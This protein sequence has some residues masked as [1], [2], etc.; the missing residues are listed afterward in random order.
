MYFL[1]SPVCTLGAV[2]DGLLSIPPQDHTA[3][4]LHEAFPGVALCQSKSLNPR[5]RHVVGDCH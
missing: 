3:N 5:F 1:P 2:K 4:K